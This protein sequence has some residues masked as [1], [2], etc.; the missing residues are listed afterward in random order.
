MQDSGAM[1]QRDMMVNKENTSGVGKDPRL[2]PMVA[3]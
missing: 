1:I 2:V 3:R